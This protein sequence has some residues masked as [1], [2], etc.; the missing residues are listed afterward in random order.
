MRRMHNALRLTPTRRNLFV[1]ALLLVGAIRVGLWLLPFRM[2]RSL[3]RT[4]MP[5]QDGDPTEDWGMV[6][7]I[8]WAV[9]L[10]S[11][12]VP[13][14]SCLTQALATQVLLRRRGYPAHIRIGVTRDTGGALEAHAWV[15]SQGLIVIG[16]PE[17]RVAR[18]TPLPP[19][20]GK[21]V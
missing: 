21:R 19:W 4:I 5:Q 1:Q 3:L 17:K 6:K 14:A 20:E 9:Q 12:Y 8:S 7:R 15:E 10:A 13:A 2:L 16:G 18:F 11:R